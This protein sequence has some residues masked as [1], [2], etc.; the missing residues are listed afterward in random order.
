LS[1]AKTTISGVFWTFSQQFSVQLINFLVQI[2]LAR[3]LVPAEFGLLAMIAV[4]NSIGTALMDGGMTASLIR[5]PKPDNEDYSSVFYI[6]LVVSLVIYFILFTCSPLIASFYKQPVLSAIIRVYSLS[7]VVTALVGVQTTRLTKEMR[8]KTQ[9][10]MQI[11]SVIVGGIVG[12]IL[13]HFGFGVWSLVWMNLVESILFTAQHWIF[14]GWY[15]SFVINKN[16]LAHHFNFGYKLT[17]ASISNA[18]FSNVYNIIVGKYFS[19]SQVGLYNRAYTIQMFPV[20]NISTALDKVTFPVFASI[21][22]DIKLKLAYKKIMQQVMLWVVPLVIFLGILAKPLFTILLTEKWLPAVPYFQ[23]LC[24]VGM[25]WPMQLYN[26]NILKVKGKSA[27]ILKL[28]TFKRITFIVCIISSISFGMTA[29]VVMQSV[30]AVFSYIYNS[31]YSGK[32]INYNIWSQLRDITPF[33]LLGLTAGAFIVAG[34]NYLYSDLS[35][36]LQL[37]IGFVTGFAIYISS[38]ILFKVEAFKE[39]TNIATNILLKKRKIKIITER[40]T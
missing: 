18:I 38:T 15:P 13:A 37:I 35:Q 23:I 7:F 29:L 1:L 19:V 24:V 5:T 2:I 32:F 6:N 16:K 10:A 12:I 22:D 17:L 28:N 34:T 36:L 9:M 40:T 3:M 33:V 31:H 20:F 4:F 25:L 39:F 30:N 27:L 8:F 14:S 11:P 26:I 21:D